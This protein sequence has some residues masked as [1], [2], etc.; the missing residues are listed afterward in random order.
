MKRKHPAN[1]SRRP[2]LPGGGHRSGPSG[3][4]QPDFARRAGKSR[5]VH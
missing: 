1:P 4:P 2:D 3:K 5:K